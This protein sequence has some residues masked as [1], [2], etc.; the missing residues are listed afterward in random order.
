M[1]D[2]ITVVCAADNAFALPMAVMLQSMSHNLAKDRVAQVHILDGGITAENRRKIGNSCT[3]KRI[4]LH[5]W[6]ADIT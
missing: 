6:N 2:T 5:W 3:D 1:P 4:S